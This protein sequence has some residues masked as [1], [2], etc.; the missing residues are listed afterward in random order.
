MQALVK[1]GSND[2]EV[3]IQ[4]IGEPELPPDRVMLRVESAGVCGSDLHMWREHHSWTIKM[5]LVLGHE[6][7][8]RVTDVGR[9][10]RGIEPGMRVACETAAEICG[11]CVYCL[12]GAVQLVPRPTW[13]W[14]TG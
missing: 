10:V 5:P 3:E 9:H 2:G 11:R 12:G 4:E 13:L 14:R 8:A 6:F 7:C 1:Y